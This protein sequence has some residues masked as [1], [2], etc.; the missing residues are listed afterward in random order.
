MSKSN[1]LRL[2]QPS[3]E[4]VVY[5]E[6]ACIPYGKDSWPNGYIWLSSSKLKRLESSDNLRLGVEVDLTGIGKLL[7]L[8]SKLVSSDEMGAKMEAK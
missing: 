6:E 7:G 2:S 8:I 5:A 1:P 4:S 3:E